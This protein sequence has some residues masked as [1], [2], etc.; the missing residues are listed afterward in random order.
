MTWV[1]Q[2]DSKAQSL[3]EEIKEISQAASVIRRRYWGLHEISIG[4]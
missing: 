4:M 2:L 1:H 3:E